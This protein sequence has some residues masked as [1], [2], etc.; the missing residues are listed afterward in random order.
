MNRRAFISGLSLIILATLLAAKA[1]APEKLPKIGYLSG[2]EPGPREDAFQQGLRELGY[3]KGRNIAI[4]WRFAEGREDRLADLASDLV[5][6]GV[7]VIVADGTRVIRAAKNATTTIPIIMLAAADPIRTGF[8]TSLGRP[9][10]NITGLAQMM[11]ELASKRLELLK[12][13]IPRLSRVAVL[14]NPRD[15]AVTLVF[16]ETQASARTLGVQLQSLQVRGPDDF[17][18]A[19]GAA[20]RKEVSALVVLSDALL[21]TH[22]LRIVELATRRRL[23][24]IY[25]QR[26]WVEAGGLMSY[27]TNFIDL[28]RR[29]ATYIDRILKGAKPAD[30]PVEQPTK[31]ELVINMKTARALG[32]TIPLSLLLRADR[33]IE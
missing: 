15:P 2:S 11:P 24:A 20:A 27:G 29:A 14:W 17:D 5:R 9:G 31:F 26:L 6:L 32:L 30:L 3:V 23:P 21:F 12:E 19:F 10:G 22:R 13:V 28:W 7:D 18:S 33:V 16:H 4:E 8:V 1:Q 25:A